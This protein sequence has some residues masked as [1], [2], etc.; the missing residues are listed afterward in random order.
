M[1]TIVPIIFIVLGVLAVAE[2]V[3]AGL[4][5]AILVGWALVF[6]GLAHLIGAF[7]G[8][9]IGRA[10]WQGVV[11]VVYAF[12]GVYFLTHPLI[13]LGT[14]TLFLAM[15]LFVEAA[16]ELMVWGATRALPGAAW[17]LFNG[18]VTALL[19]V[20]IWVHWPSTSVWAIGTLVGVNLLMTGV[21]RLMLASAG[22]RIAS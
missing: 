1:S 5:V 8:G 22:R 21:S 16:F 2:P 7:A 12:C 14:L 9:G 4:A 11:G 18:L 17:R 20:L 10:V 6:A 13:G 15:V 3:V 19:A